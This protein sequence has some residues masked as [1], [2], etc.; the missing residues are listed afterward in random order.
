[1][2]VCYTLTRLQVAVV[3]RVIHH[4]VLRDHELL[5]QQLTGHSIDRAR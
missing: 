5:T 2:Q 4:Y 3:E 1:M